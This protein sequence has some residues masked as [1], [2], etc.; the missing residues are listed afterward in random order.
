VNAISCQLEKVIGAVKW[1]HD[2]LTE[3]LD[4]CEDAVLILSSI[5]NFRFVASVRL[6][7]NVLRLK[8][9]LFI[10]HLVNAEL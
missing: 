8:K 6:V 2:T 1:L 3:A 7:R 4:T 10:K 9:Q 5:A